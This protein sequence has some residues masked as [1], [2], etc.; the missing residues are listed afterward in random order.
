M[1]DISKPS[2]IR[3]RIAFLLFDG[4]KMLD[5]VV[6]A[7]VFVEANQAVDGYD[8][9]LLSPDG[10]DVVTSLGSRVSVHGAALDAGSF[11]TVIV[12]GSELP[13][14]EFV[15]GP[16]TEAAAALASRARRVVSICSG[17]LSQ[18][19]PDRYSTRQEW[20]TCVTCATPRRRMTSRY[21]SDDYIS[22]TC[23]PGTRRTCCGG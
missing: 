4:V 10:K 20:P 21:C 12:P 5:Y 9:V 22:A 14:H 3:R 2:R 8:I 7:E 11:D 23:C 13:P 17:A 6:P 16:V 19:F 15:R 18:A 1:T